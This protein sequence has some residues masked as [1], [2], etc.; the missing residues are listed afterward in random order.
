MN[1]KKQYNSENKV[2]K[3]LLSGDQW[4]CYQAFRALNQAVGRCIRH[5]YDYGAIILLDERYKIASNLDYL[6]KW[7][8]TSIQPM[9]SFEQSLE[10]LKSF[11]K[12]VEASSTKCTTENAKARSNSSPS[13]EN[14]G[15]IGVMAT[16]EKQRFMEQ[17]KPNEVNHSCN[18]ALQSECHSSGVNAEKVTENLHC[19]SKLN[20]KTAVHRSPLQEIFT[21]S[22]VDFESAPAES[23][24]I[25]L[26]E[27]P[28]LGTPWALTRSSCT[29]LI[30]KSI[31]KKR[32][33]DPDSREKVTPITS[34]VGSCTK[35]S[36]TG[37]LSRRE[38]TQPTSSEVHSTCFSEDVESCPKEQLP[39]SPY[40]S[41]ERVTESYPGDALCTMEVE[42]LSCLDP[43]IRSLS[44]DFV[45]CTN[46]MVDDSTTCISYKVS[47]LQGNAAFNEELETRVEPCAKNQEGNAGTES[48]CGTEGAI[49]CCRCGESLLRVPQQ[50]KHVGWHK[51]TLKKKFLKGLIDSFSVSGEVPSLDHIDVLVFEMSW[52]H[53]HLPQLK[54]AHNCSME[55]NKVNQEIQPSQAVWVEEDGCV[56]QPLFCPWCGD[57]P[58]CIGALVLAANRANMDLVDMALLFVN[59]LTLHREPGA[60][61][62]SCTQQEQETTEKTRSFCESPGRQSVW[63]GHPNSFP[64]RGEHTPS[65][66]KLKL[67]RRDQS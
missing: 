51:A 29:P 11:F 57:E 33:V 9:E 60:A 13:S 45:A 25:K 17:S 63:V 5:R 16:P 30:E 56:F 37:C 34:T 22:N 48:S 24:S 55:L 38:L 26:L 39:L 14:N 67:P 4:Y 62:Q 50:Q 8:R 66:I 7:L 36:K 12:R 21:Q 15:L 54:A 19:I 32:L 20:N 65:R 47:S 23:G 18:T 40:D 52:L 46:S 31:L 44:S 28:K 64:K 35:R 43:L 58:F 53:P 2:S 42:K 49:L 27:S 1:M 41:I 3:H 6:S 10:G 61:N 59:A